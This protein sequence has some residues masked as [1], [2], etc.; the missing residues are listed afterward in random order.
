MT[1][2]RRINPAVYDM[3]PADLFRKL[4]KL[5]LATDRG[6]AT[7]M[8]KNEELLVP[9]I[10]EVLGEEKARLARRRHFYL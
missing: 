7:W 4:M 1:L 9:A 8:S 10:A 6:L 2:S 5:A 3:H